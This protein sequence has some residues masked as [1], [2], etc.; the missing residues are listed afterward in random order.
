VKNKALESADHL[1]PEWAS[2]SVQQILVGFVVLTICF[3]LSWL[4]LLIA[5][6]TVIWM[7]LAVSWFGLAWQ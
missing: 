7:V 5:P 2:P 4:F 1:I 6:G 3:A